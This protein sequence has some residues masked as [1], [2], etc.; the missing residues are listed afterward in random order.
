MQ[1]AIAPVERL[2]ALGALFLARRRFAAALIGPVR[3][4]AGL[5]RGALAAEGVA[6]RF[7]V[8][9]AAVGVLRC[10]EVLGAAGASVD[11][12]RIRHPEPCAAA[13]RPDPG[14]DEH[15]EDRGSTEGPESH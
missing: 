2:A 4:T 8:Q 15:C 3:T 12:R 11:G 5:R 10:A 7:V 9:Q 1:G 6:T 14:N 13:G